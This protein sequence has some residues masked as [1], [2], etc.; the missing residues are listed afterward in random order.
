MS[1]TNK[2]LKQENSLLVRTYLAVNLII[3]WALSTGT[4]FTEAFKT[5]EPRIDKIIESGTISLLICIF[6]VVICG[7]LSSDFK[8]ILIFKKLKNT[9]PGH[10]AFSYYMQNDPRINQTNLYRKFGEIPSDPIEQNQ[11]W[12]RIY[13]KRE[14][15]KIVSD[16]HRN[17][18]LLRELTGLGF[19]FLFILVG[20]SF[21]VFSDHETS[22]FY[23]LALL[24]LFLFSSQAAQNCGTRLIINVLAIESVTE[25]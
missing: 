15:D 4:T 19:L 10:R 5:P 9:L 6:T 16:T 14:D 3:F 17:F 20:A 12:Y 18:L 23:T 7:L 11:L 22:L 1:D 21:F 2:T 8:Y 13:K 25:E 24:T